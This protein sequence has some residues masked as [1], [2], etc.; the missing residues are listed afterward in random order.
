MDSV[1]ARY[2]K[3]CGWT[4]CRSYGLMIGMLLVCNKD[5]YLNG[6]RY[7]DVGPGVGDIQSQ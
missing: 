6:D 5:R 3:F 2:C 4:R 7:L 1:D